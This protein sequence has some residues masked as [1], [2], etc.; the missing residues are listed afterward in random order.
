MQGLST[1][2][3]APAVWCLCCPSDLCCVRE[4]QELFIVALPKTSQLDDQN[5]LDD[6]GNMPTRALFIITLPCSSSMTFLCTW[7]LSQ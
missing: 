2:P 7:R 6:L 1:A 4:R 3:A 5:A